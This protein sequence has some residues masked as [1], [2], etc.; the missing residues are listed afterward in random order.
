MKKIILSILVIGVTLF[1]VGCDFGSTTTTTV[2]TITTEEDTTIYEIY[3]VLELQSIDMSKSYI[4]MNDLD[5]QDIEWIPL[6][7]YL[8]PYDGTFDGNGFTI[9]NMSITNKNDYYNGLFASISGNILNLTLDQASIAYSS[10]FISYAGLLAGSTTGDVTNVTV[11]GDI[12]ITSTSGNTYVGLLAGFTSANITATMIAEEFVPNTISG[13]YAE[14]SIDAT[15]P[16]FLFAGGLIGKAYNSEVLDSFVNVGIT[17]KTNIYRAYVGGLIGHHYGGILIGYEEFVDSTDILIARNLVFSNIEV[18]SNG[19]NTSIGGIVG[20]SQYSVVKDNIASTSVSVSGESIYFGSFLGE[21]WNSTLE[22]SL[23]ISDVTIEETETQ[24]LELNNVVGI[25]NLESVKTN[26]YY[27]ISSNLTV[28]LE[29]ATLAT[30]L[31]ITDETWLN[32]TFDFTLNHSYFTEA[33]AL[34][35]E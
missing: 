14:G 5:L 24:I 9:S 10:N 34:L 12:T 4:L 26:L 6:G 23:G 11:S 32:S 30:S 17:A 25:S 19:T 8:T 35:S 2:T 7:S 22:D 16:N 28:T 20:Y 31:Q 3:T 33:L 29:E 27:V 1:L 15:C 18:T 21:S 13:I